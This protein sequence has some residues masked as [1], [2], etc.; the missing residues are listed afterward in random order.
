VVGSHYRDGKPEEEIAR[1]AE[2]LEVSLIVVGGRKVGR[3]ASLFATS[4]SEAVYGRARCAVLVARG[5]KA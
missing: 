4:F 5:P 2:E 3:F 1:L